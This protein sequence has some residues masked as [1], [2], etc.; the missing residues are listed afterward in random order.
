[1]FS[2]FYTLIPP[3][4]RWWELRAFYA[5]SCQSCCSAKSQPVQSFI[6]YFLTNFY[7]FCLSSPRPYLC[8]LLSVSLSLSISLFLSL[9]PSLSQLNPF[10]DCTFFVGPLTRV[11]TESTDKWMASKN[12]Q[13]M[14]ERQNHRNRTANTF[15]WQSSCITLIERP[16]LQLVKQNWRV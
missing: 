14:R 5:L 16:L 7:L 6:Y 9:F 11:S 2:C 10:L 15:H 12:R 8:L 4:R 1:M 3:R 13:K